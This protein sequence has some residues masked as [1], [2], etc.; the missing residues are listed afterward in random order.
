MLATLNHTYIAQ[1]RSRENLFFDAC[2]FSGKDGRGLVR[3]KKVGEWK[4]WW[5][6]VVG[7]LKVFF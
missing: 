2:S 4:V 6:E 3:E 7:R 1:K 5:F